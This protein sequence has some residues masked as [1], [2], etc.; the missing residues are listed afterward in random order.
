MVDMPKVILDGAVLPEEGLGQ[1]LVQGRGADVPV[2]FGSNR[3]EMKLFLFLDSRY[4]RRW[5]GVLPQV[6]DEARLFRDAEYQSLVWKASGVDG[7]AEPLARRRPGQVFGY[8]FDWDEE[9]RIL[10]ADLGEL[11][12]AAH[13]FEIPFVFGHWEL[14]R[15]GEVLFTEANAAGRE[16]LSAAMR[17]YWA[18]FARHGDP[19]RGGSRERTRWQ[20]WDAS[21][22]A[23]PRYL[24]LDTPAGGGLAMRAE[25][26]SA[27]ALLERLGQD[28]RFAD[29]ASRCRM[30]R[31]LVERSWLLREDEV[32]RIA[33]GL[34]AHAASRPRIGS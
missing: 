17:G 31:T 19:G 5:F 20:P 15:Q 21:G 28:P 27:E 8:R 23:T 1:T 24:R 14:G 2:I 7:L 12:G 6:K 11:L 9:P 29:S 16:T 33:G 25:K 3:D 18:E 32:S 30:A 26:V 4:V 10:W 22:P 13:G 34:C